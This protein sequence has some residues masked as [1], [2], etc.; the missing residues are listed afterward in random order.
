MTW[1]VVFMRCLLAVLCGLLFAC[2]GGG[3]GGGES[4]PQPPPE[5]Q[6]PTIAI[7]QVF[8]QLTFDQPMVMVQAPG[9]ETVWFIAERA[10]RVWRFQA[11]D[12]VAS[13]SLVVDIS[14][15]V[16]TEGEGGL[17]GM[18]FHPQ[19]AD[20][21]RVFLSYT[22]PLS[23]LESRL[24]EFLSFDGGQTFAADS[25]RLVLTVLQDFSNHNGGHVAFGADSFVYFGLG[26]GGSGND[27]NG[28]AQDTTNLLGAMLR[29]DVDGAQPYAI[30]SDNPFAGNPPCVQGFGA[31]DCP[32][33]YAWGLRNPWRFNFDTQTGDLW[34]G[35]VGQNDWEEIDLVEAGGN[36]GWPIREG[37]HCNPNLGG[38][39][40]VTSGF[41]DPVAEYGRDLGKSITGGYVYRGEAIPALLGSYLFG[42]FV[43]GRLW[44]IDAASGNFNLDEL[45]Q[46]TLAIASLAEG[47]DGELYVLD[48]GSGGIFRIN[49]TN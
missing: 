11:V 18:A 34:L 1:A 39:D 37:A 30:P 23:P 19:F 3:G 20:N 48:F 31:G 29:I 5:P 8:A 21:G 28:R 12:D 43:S 49:G 17:L 42:D 44:R 40:C 41:I 9:D 36:Y 6:A 46:T 4:A 26:D 38:D 15:R 2:S 47:L 33:I 24:S 27:P 7:E 14:N 13:A 16:S 35:D 45:A 25:E 22:A 10:G 32:E